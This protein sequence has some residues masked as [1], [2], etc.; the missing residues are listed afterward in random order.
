VKYRGEQIVVIFIAYWYVHSRVTPCTNAIR[1]NRST[2][3]QDLTFRHRASS[4]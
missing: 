2:R 4:V 1:V 3:Q